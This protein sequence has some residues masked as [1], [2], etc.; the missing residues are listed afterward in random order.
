MQ[1]VIEECGGF[2]KLLPSWVYACPLDPEAEAA[3]I[4]F[5]ARAG[6]DGATF[7]NTPDF[8]ESRLTLD[9]SRAWKDGGGGQDWR[10]KRAWR[11][12]E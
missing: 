9:L 1:F 8:G 4:T 12:V 7:I 5:R 3:V 6:T 11:R 10:T 2:F